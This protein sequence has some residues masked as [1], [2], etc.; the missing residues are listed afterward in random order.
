MTDDE[1]RLLIL[2][3]AAA[4]LAEKLAKDRDPAYWNDDVLAPLNGVLDAVRNDKL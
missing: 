3:E 2:L 4:K 1:T